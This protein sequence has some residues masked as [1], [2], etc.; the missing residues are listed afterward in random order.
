MSRAEYMRIH[1]KYFPTY[2]RYQYKIDGLIEADGYVYIKLIKG[3][4]GLKQASIIAYNKI[5]SHMD[6]HGYYPVPFTTGLWAHNTIKKMS[7][8]R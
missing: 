1:S 6:T 3:I 5:I 2:I 7:L 4:Y 8:C